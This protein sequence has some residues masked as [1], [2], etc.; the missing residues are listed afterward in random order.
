MLAFA[1]LVGITALK[2]GITITVFELVKK[3]F[4]PEQKKPVKLTPEEG[5]VE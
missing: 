4:E 2:A 5:K 3:L 1:K